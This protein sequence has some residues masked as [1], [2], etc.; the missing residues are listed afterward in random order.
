MSICSLLEGY[1]LP[2]LSQVPTSKS[3]YCVVF[4]NIAKGGRTSVQMPTHM[5][6]LPETYVMLIPS[7]TI[8]RVIA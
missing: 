5:I 7:I 3:L 2:R 6:V 4:S 1:K 8:E